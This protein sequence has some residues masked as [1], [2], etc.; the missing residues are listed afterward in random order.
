MVRNWADLSQEL[1]EL[2]SQNLCPKDLWAFRAV[3]Q[4]WR[5]APLKERSNVP[6]MM[7]ED[8]HETLWRECFCLSCQR[9]HR[10]LMPEAKGKTCFSSRGWVFTLGRDWE[11]YMLKNPMSHHNYIIKLPKLKFPDIE[12]LPH[13]D[14]FSAKFVLSASPTTSLDYMVMVIYGRGGRLGFWKPGDKEWTAVDYPSPTCWDLVFY[15]GCFVAVDCEGSILRCDVN[16]PTPFE[17]QVIFRMPRRLVH[18]EHPDLV[19]PTTGH[20]LLMSGVYLVQS[21]TGSLLFVSR[22]E[23]REPAR[24]FRFQVFE[25][26]LNTQTYTEVKSLGS[27]SLFL[28]SNSSFYLEANE[29][30]HIKPDCIY[31]A[32]DSWP[33]LSEEGGG[34]DMGIYHIEDRTTELY[35][36]AM[37]YDHYSFPLWI[38]PSF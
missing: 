32:D 18:W 9:V 12:D 37:A 13:Y 34:R 15:K 21:P 7:L 16:G 22:W 1:L 20:R 23:E 10:V 2:C 3:C 17:T 30:H 27:T 11:V 25:I 31:F 6:W 19:Q 33:W 24:T 4:S 5:S 14:N 8:H 36:M 28:G 29:E 26:D 38:E 35:F